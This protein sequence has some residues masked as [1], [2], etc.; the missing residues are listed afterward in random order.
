MVEILPRELR[1]FVKAS[2]G[3]LEGVT[4]DTQLC[5]VA[6]VYFRNVVLVGDY[7][8]HALRFSGG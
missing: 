3:S 6:S 5:F 2:A 1:V 8:V 7:V 4:G